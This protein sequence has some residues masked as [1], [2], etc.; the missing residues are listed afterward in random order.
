MKIPTQLVME[1]IIDRPA[2]LREPVMD[3][4]EIHWPDVPNMPELPNMPDLPDMSDIWSALQKAYLVAV[5]KAG[6]ILQWLADNPTVVFIAALVISSVLAHRFILSSLLSI[7]GFGPLGV[8]KGSLAAFIHSNLVVIQ[9]GSAFAIAQSAGAGG[10]GLAMLGKGF[11]MIVV[12]I[13]VVLMAYHMLSS[14][15]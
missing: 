14:G 4:L 13:L 12:V 8:I 9:A 6:E 5:D 2:T 11:V 3:N 7:S 1:K 10:A 15:S